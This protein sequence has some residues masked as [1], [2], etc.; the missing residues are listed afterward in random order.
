MANLSNTECPWKNFY[1]NALNY[2]DSLH[3]ETCQPQIKI[4][5]FIVA[6]RHCFASPDV[7]PKGS[8]KSTEQLKEKMEYPINSIKKAQQTTGI[9]AGQQLLNARI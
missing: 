3:A 1:T 5:K 4:A 6:A 7:N 9:H 8:K 2:M